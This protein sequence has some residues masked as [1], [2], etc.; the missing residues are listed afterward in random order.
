MTRELRKE[1]KVG[2]LA[3]GGVSGVF[4]VGERR[5]GDVGWEEGTGEMGRAQ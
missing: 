1:V 4:V 5:G 2:S 3:E